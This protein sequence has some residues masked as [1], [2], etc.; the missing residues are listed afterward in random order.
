MNKKTILKKTTHLS[1]LLFLGLVSSKQAEP[2]VVVYVTLFGLWHLQQHE[3]I[4]L[5]FLAIHVG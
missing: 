5:D 4:V 2:Y 1:R 3:I